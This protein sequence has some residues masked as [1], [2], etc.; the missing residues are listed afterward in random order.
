MDFCSFADIGETANTEMNALKMSGGFAATETS[1]YRDIHLTGGI[2]Q[3]G[4]IESFS[5]DL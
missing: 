1:R 2:A 5:R 3:L 4:L